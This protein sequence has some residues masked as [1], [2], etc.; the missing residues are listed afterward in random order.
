MKKK[1]IPPRSRSLAPA[2]PLSPPRKPLSGVP[3]PKFRVPD[4]EADRELL[5][6][7]A[8]DF[9]ETGAIPESLTLE[10]LERVTAKGPLPDE[11]EDLFSGLARLVEVLREVKRGQ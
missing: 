5:R 8:R 2:D 9:M 1:M 11:D 4:V 10:D 3:D 7:V 6:K